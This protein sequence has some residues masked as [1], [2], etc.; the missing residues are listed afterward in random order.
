MATEHPKITVYIPKEILE[1]LSQNSYPK[2][3]VE[4]HYTFGSFHVIATG[5]RVSFLHSLESWWIDKLSS[6]A[7]LIILQGFDPEKLFWQRF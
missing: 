6:V 5:T 3:F 1:A 4:S 2:R 7:F